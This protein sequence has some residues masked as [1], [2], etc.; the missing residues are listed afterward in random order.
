MRLRNSQSDQRLAAQSRTFGTAE[1][2]A[3]CSS[4]ALNVIRLK[5][6]PGE[7]LCFQSTCNQIIS[8]R[9]GMEFLSRESDQIRVPPSAPKAADGKSLSMRPRRGP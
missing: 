6:K 7:A 8:F 3:D 4:S 5:V 1:C 9:K 2:Q